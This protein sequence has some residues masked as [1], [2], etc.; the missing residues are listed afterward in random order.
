MPGCGK[1]TIGREL[2]RRLNKRF[3]DTDMEIE[4]ETG[5]TPT[6]IINENGEA[7]FRELESRAVITAAKNSGQII[8]TGGGSVLLSQNR[9]AL[10]QN[11]FIIF[12]VKDIKLLATTA[13]P[14]SHDLTA[15][16]QMAETRVPIYNELCHE[17]IIVKDALEENIIR[18][19]EKLK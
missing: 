10:L 2:A 12:L 13:R 11:S 14:L 15:L 4:R 19:T 6:E 16:Y 9:E 7:Y 18:I 17:K 3:I 1:T 5:K 8:A